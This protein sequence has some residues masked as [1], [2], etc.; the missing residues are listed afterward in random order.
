MGGSGEMVEAWR[1]R[2]DVSSGGF[3]RVGSERFQFKLFSDV[4]IFFFSFGFMEGTLEG[5]KEW[6]SLV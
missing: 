6:L 5:R 3:W 1:G 4:Y 2:G